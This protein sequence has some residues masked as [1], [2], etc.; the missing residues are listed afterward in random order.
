MHPFFKRYHL[1]R[2]LAVR[3][4]STVE[5]VRTHLSQQKNQVSQLN[6]TLSSI[7]SW[8]RSSAD[9]TRQPRRFLDDHPQT[10][11]GKFPQISLSSSDLPEGF[12]AQIKRIEAA[13]EIC[14]QV[15]ELNRQ[16]SL[17]VKM[18]SQWLAE[19]PS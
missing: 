7:H 4:S 16:C 9:T 18:L 6:T 12:E 11:Y 10:T 19:M 13:Q 2:H 8:A 3:S 5:Q 15:N 14:A 17:D 1:L